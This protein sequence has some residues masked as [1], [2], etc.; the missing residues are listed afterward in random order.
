[1]INNIRKEIASVSKFVYN[2]PIV[3]EINTV[4]RLIKKSAKEVFEE[5]GGGWQ[6]TIYQGAMEVALRQKGIMYET[7]R[8]LPISF[9]DHVVGESKP[10]LVIWVQSKSKKIA[11][12]VDLKAE[13]GLKEE[14]EVQVLRYIQEL[15]KQ[16]HTN[17][18]VFNKGLV[19]NFVREKTTKT[20]QEGFEDLGGVQV[21]EVES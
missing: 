8:I 4:I 5:L 19:I 6:E 12:V 1:M 16:I 3:M 20:L 10:D 11:I 14:N 17:E 18:K 13:K 2:F 15:K 21:L 9:K 7:Q